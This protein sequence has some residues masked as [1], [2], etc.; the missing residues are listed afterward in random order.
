MN[1]QLIHAFKKSESE[2]VRLSLREFKGKTY[3]DLRIFFCAK[4]SNEF[5]PSRKGVI[6][7]VAHASELEKAFQG[8]SVKAAGSVVQ[9]A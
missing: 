1:D 3:V 4:G 6:L 9:T 8:L 5:A 7:S 2:E